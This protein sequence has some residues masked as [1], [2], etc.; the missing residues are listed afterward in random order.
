MIETV[1]GIRSHHEKQEWVKPDR[2][3]WY[4]QGNRIIPG[5]LGGAGFLVTLGFGLALSACSF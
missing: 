4:L 1:D 2:L 3:L 5:F